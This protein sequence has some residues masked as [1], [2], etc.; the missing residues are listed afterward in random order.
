MKTTRIVALSDTHNRHSKITVPDGD[1]L[2]H[3][4]DATIG[5]NGS[6]IERFLKWFGKQEHQHKIFVAGN[7]DR[8]FEDD[9]VMARKLC[10]KN[11]II[12]L[13]DSG[14]EIYGLKFY[15]SPVQPW[16]MDWAFNRARSESEASHRNIKLIK[17][18]WDKIPR[19]TDILI[20]H[21][22]AYEMLDMVEANVGCPFDRHF[23][24]EDLADAIKRIKP[25]VHIF[26]HI[27]AGYG[28]D[29]INGTSSY[30]VSVCDEMYLPTN[31]ITVID[32]DE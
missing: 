27:H 1:I 9:P 23:G 19:D 11:Q 29:H 22:P 12:Y 13:E 18:H 7:H 31:P 20:T 2:I 3:A 15:G 8:L 32:Y 21:S 5:G 17:P 14:C 6:E 26:G 24:C 10:A 25:K 28:Q 16:F 30:N 4:G